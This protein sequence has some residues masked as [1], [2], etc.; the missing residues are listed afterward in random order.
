MTS[1]WRELKRRNV[2]RVAIAYAI[3][4]WLLLQ[5]AD[6]VLGN[7]EAPT[8][9]FQ[10][11]LLMLIIGFPLALIFAW[12]FELTP[13]GIK[14]E[15]DVDRSDSVT[16]VTGR[17]L[18]FI[19]IGVMAIAIAYFLVDKFVW[20]G[21]E[22]PTGVAVSE[23]RKSIAVLPFANR[24]ANEGD[25]FFVDGIHDDLLS[26]ISKIGSIKTI[27]RTS[28][29]QYRDTTKTIPQ[30]AKELGVATVLE[31]GVQ[32]AGEQV[33]INVQLIDARTDEHIWSE[34]YD[35]HLTAA[36]IFAIQS[37][38]ATSIADALRATL[39]PDEQQQLDTVP[40]ESLAAY[41][42]YIK[43]RFWA[44]KT[45]GQGWPKA[46]EHYEEAVRLD[47]NFALAHAG[48]ADAYANNANWGGVPARVAYPKAKQAADDAL[49]LN[50]KLA[51]A[52]A[53]QA[54]V[55]L[56]FEWDWEGA[57]TAFRYALTLNPSN[58]QA[59]HHFGHYLDFK[60]SYQ[61]SL[62][63]FDKALALDPLSAFQWCGRAYTLLNM[64][65]FESAHV[66][67]DRALELDPGLPMRWTVL[68]MLH[69][70]RGEFEEAVSAWERSLSLEP[71]V[72]YQNALLGYGYAR[73]GR[74]DD[75]NAVLEMLIRST[76]PGVGAMHRA[77]I[78]AALGD[79]DNA[80]RMLEQALVDREPWII[81]LKIDSGFS[82]MNHDPRFASILE[83]AGISN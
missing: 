33:R 62:D 31:G 12:A 35:R 24:S 60:E 47:P 41:D 54:L 53:A 30:I 21:E 68:G 9:L 57:D 67:L 44:G 27:S 16:P 29:L 23:V 22:L 46:I 69:N 66:A 15:K 39:S 50:S 55:K 8:W 37:E 81:G 51:E 48:L 32:R 58:A 52:H 65:E 1:V 61:E 80:F 25:A 83:R 77:P 70:A 42:A 19:I 26:H 17:K 10:A 64:G 20:V 59:F 63:A 38:I 13:E 56:F 76:L 18:N 34:I 82:L 6:V 11:I 78:F 71:G 4:A 28:V 49:R 74:I 2:V 45:T 72:P 43:G 3:V 73:V 79:F 75:A 7:I 5:V 40:T 14:K 36:N